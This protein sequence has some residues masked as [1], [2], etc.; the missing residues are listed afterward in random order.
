MATSVPVPMAMPTS[1][2]ASA[3]ASFTPSPAM[4]TTFPWARSSRTMRCLSSGST[5]PWN[6]S[7]PSLRATASAVVRLSPV[8]MT[9]WMP[10]ARRL[11][12][13]AG[14]LCLTGSATAMTPPG[15]PST[16]RKSAVPPS[17]RSS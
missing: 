8:S 1:A 4:A 5:S 12:S 11:S 16:A 9:M 7:M 6:S 2:S 3:G 17:R 14:V 10:L 15:L 13:A